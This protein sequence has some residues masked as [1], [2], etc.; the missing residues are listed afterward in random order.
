MVVVMNRKDCMSRLSYF[1]NFCLLIFSISFF[2]RVLKNKPG[3]QA[4]EI[5]LENLP[6]KIS[7]DAKKGNINS[8]N[9]AIGEKIFA[10]SLIDFFNKISL[11]PLMA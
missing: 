10:F 3:P 5:D 8:I 11:V 1:T 4:P 2:R 9:G 7:T 6:L